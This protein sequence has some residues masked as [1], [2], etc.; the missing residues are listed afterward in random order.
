[1]VLRS[2][3]LTI[4]DVVSLND[5]YELD[6]DDLNTILEMDLLGHFKAVVEYDKEEVR[7]EG[8]K[9]QKNMEK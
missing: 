2:N 7:L 8:P 5:L 1:M 3:S 4:E 9:I 6:I